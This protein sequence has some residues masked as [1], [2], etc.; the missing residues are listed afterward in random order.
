QALNLVKSGERPIAA[1][2]DSQYANEARFAGHPIQN[3]FPTHGT[4]GIPAV[5][6][7]V[8]SG[9]NRNAGKLLAEYT[10]SLDAQKLWPGNGIYAARVDVDPPAGSPAIS[11][12]KVIPMD[13]A[14]ITRAGGA[15]K[16]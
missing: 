9:K 1:G 14:Y 12:V 10:L 11:D 5:T 7:V 13:H 16:S 8:R 3:F 2:A 6:A 15:L 4:L